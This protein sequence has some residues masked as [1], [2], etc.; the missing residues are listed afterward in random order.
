[1]INFSKI[2]LLNIKSYTQIYRSKSKEL[3]TYKFK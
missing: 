3:E 2:Y 1:M